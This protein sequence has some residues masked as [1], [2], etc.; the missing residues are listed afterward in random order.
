[1]DTLRKALAPRMD[2]TAMQQALWRIEAL[3]EAI[4]DIASGSDGWQKSIARNALIVD[5]GNAALSAPEQDDGWL[6]IESAPRDGTEILICFDGDEAR[7]VIIARWN[8]HSTL[9]GDFGRFVW[10]SQAGEA[11]IAEKCVSYWRPL[12]AP[13]GATP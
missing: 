10:E 8:P 13:P 7:Q 3:R 1:M 9:P 11:G 5:D 2:G 6:S 4:T 12:P